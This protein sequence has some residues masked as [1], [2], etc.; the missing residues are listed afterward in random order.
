[1]PSFAFASVSPH[2]INHQG[3]GVSD[4]TTNVTTKAVLADSVCLLT[5][6]G[7]N[8]NQPCRQGKWRLYLSPL[9]ASSLIAM[10]HPPP[11]TILWPMGGHRTVLLPEATSICHNLLQ[12]TLTWQGWIPQLSSTKGGGEAMS[13]CDVSVLHKELLYCTNW[14]WKDMLLYWPR[15]WGGEVI[16]KIHHVFYMWIGHPRGWVCGRNGHNLWL[17]EPPMAL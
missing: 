9:Q 14:L 17:L 12:L 6:H 3:Q 11:V 16:G 2:Q 10:P 7:Q 4:V 8:Q 13:W 15:Y 5:Y 1:M